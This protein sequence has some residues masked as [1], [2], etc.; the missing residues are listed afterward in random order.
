MWKKVRKTFKEKAALKAAFFWR[1]EQKAVID[2]SLSMLTAFKLTQPVVPG[3]DGDSI[4]RQAFMLRSMAPK[5]KKTT[6]K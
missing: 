3:G 6:R 4:W 2:K 5:P 1:F